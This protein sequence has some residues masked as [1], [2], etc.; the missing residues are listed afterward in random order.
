MKKNL[1][2]TVLTLFAATVLAQSP[3]AKPQ[4]NKTTTPQQV[5]AQ[6]APQPTN[7]SSSSSAVTPKPKKPTASVGDCLDYLKKISGGTPKDK[8][9]IE[10]RQK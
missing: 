6:T 10:Q 2:L 4:K 5:P 8:K 1:L 7:A 9:P 3:A